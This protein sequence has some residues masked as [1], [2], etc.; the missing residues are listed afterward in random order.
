ML[1]LTAK[2]DIKELPAG[3]TVSRD[4]RDEYG[5]ILGQKN[6]EQFE[7]EVADMMGR[8][9]FYIH[10]EI[11]GKHVEIRSQI[12]SSNPDTQRDE[13]AHMLSQGLAHLGAS[14]YKNFAP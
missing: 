6:E 1:T 9:F 8:V 14:I 2:I 4:I 7:A 13:R 3:D 12:S 11:D 5:K 10:A